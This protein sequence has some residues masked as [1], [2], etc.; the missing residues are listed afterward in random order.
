LI[1]TNDDAAQDMRTHRGMF[2]V[3]DL[4]WLGLAGRSDRAKRTPKARNPRPLWP[5]KM[6]QY[7]NPNSVTRLCRLV[8]ETAVKPDSY[9]WELVD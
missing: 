8:C 5:P 2:R 9:G 1:T 3:R 6:K 7:E 4:T